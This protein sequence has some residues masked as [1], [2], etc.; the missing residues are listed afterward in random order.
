MN[1]KEY[2]KKKKYKNKNKF[3]TFYEENEVDLKKENYKRQKFDI[4]KIYDEEQ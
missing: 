3:K 4:R 1:L 2:S